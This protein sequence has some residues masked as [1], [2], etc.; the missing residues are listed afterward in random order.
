MMDHGKEL[1]PITLSNTTVAN[2]VTL[3]RV[4]VSMTSHGD[5]PSFEDESDKP[6]WWP[7]DIEWRNPKFYTQDPAHPQNGLEILRKLVKSC[8]SYHGVEDLL[9]RINEIPV[10]DDEV[11][12]VDGVEVIQL[13]DEDENQ[14]VSSAE[15]EGPV[16]VCCFCLKQFSRHD[17]VLVHQNICREN[18]KDSGS[19]SDS[20]KDSGSGSDSHKDSGSGSDSHTSEHKVTTHQAFAGGDAM[21]SLQKPAPREEK[22]HPY[23]APSSLTTVNK[24]PVVSLK[25]RS[26]KKL[27]QIMERHNQRRLMIKECKEMK[28]VP[29]TGAWWVGNRQR[30]RNT[31]HYQHP[32]R[33][34]SQDA[35]LSATCLTKKADLEAK[36]EVKQEID[37]DCEIV[38]VE[39]PLSAV[40]PPSFV[41]PPSASPRAS[42]SLISQLSRDSETSS[43]RRLSFCF[44]EDEWADKEAL[45]E[46][47]DPLQISLLTLD[48]T[49]PLGQR[50]KKY[51]KGESHLNIIKD[52][53]GYCRTEVDKD[54]YNKLRYRNNEFRI[55]FKKK[56]RGSTFVH[57]YK[58]NREDKLEFDEHIRTGLSTRSRRLQRRLPVCKVLLKKLSKAEIKSWT[59]ERKIIIAENI[60]YDDDIC[61]TQID[62]PESKI[63]GFPQEK[64][65][66]QNPVYNANQRSSPLHQNHSSRPHHP[67]NRPAFSS[68]LPPSPPHV[69]NIFRNRTTHTPSPPRNSPHHHPSS[70]SVNP[71]ARPLSNTRFT[72]GMNGQTPVAS[73]H[74]VKNGNSSQRVDK[75]PSSAHLSRHTSLAPS[76]Y[77]LDN[78]ASDSTPQPNKYSQG[79]NSRRKQ[80]LTTREYDGGPF[81]HVNGNNTFGVVGQQSAGVKKQNGGTGPNVRRLSNFDYFSIWDGKMQSSLESQHK[82]QAYGD[83]YYITDT[84]KSRPPTLSTLQHRRPPQTSFSLNNRR[85]PQTSFSTSRPR[86]TAQSN[87]QNIPSSNMKGANP[88]NSLTPSI[89]VLKNTRPSLQEPSAQ[90]SSLMEHLKNTVSVPSTFLN[91]DD[92]IQE[93]ICIDDD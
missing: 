56:R 72:S 31:S 83:T 14:D 5:V 90:S 29:S 54:S 47:R 64:K 85:P 3:I 48:L 69:P 30:R 1:P 67:V 65:I 9:C 4:L 55:T 35:F 76:T 6:A 59:E 61:I 91:D 21:V 86:S 52:I 66:T 15:S 33:Y 84:P 19:G 80:Q 71:A 38:S 70:R 87:V 22:P 82:P 45:E 37:L 92:D 57:K 63:Q 20:H 27:D 10:S 2:L 53:E 11:E 46:G 58:F 40:P 79:F 7:A 77:S 32:S 75:L 89:P 28:E 16:F 24:K 73:N 8:Y 13:N 93:I 17:A 34:L 88:R 51:V 78:S 36:S 18:H 49:S 44:V 23:T 25:T 81:S 68:H 62:I 12:V 39:G 43:R 60:I 41:K 74:H 50:I 42:R 26:Q